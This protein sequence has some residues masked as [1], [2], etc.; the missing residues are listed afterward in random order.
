M[1]VIFS[2]PRIPLFQLPF[3]D[4]VK[5]KSYFFKATLKLFHIKVKLLSRCMGITTTT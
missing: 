1:D 4:T 3:G 5:H 2:S